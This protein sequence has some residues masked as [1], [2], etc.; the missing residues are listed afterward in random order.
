MEQRR[1]HNSSLRCYFE[2]CH[3]VGLHNSLV[4]SG[5][6]SESLDWSF[7][8]SPLVELAGKTMGV[9]GYGRIGQQVAKIARALQ[10]N[11]I[12][13]DRT[14]PDLRNETDIRCASIEDL[15]AESDVM[16]LHC[17]LLPETHGLINAKVISLMKKN[18][19]LINTSR[20]PLV[21]EQDLADALNEGRIAGAALDVLSQ[22]PPTSANPLLTAKNC[23]IT[24]HIAWA[25]HEA[26]SRLLAIAVDNLA[27]FLKGEPQNV[28]SH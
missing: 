19:I 18:A 12:I 2:L 25:T 22:E 7:W 11:V 9:I 27:M 4:H 20:G 6:W 8:R 1:L 10:M 24:P 23:I 15:L 14:L 5:E 3:N 28:I 17:P 21:V 26:R 13:S 16:S